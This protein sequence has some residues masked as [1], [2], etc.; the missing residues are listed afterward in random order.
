ML[1]FHCVLNR[2][3]RKHLRAGLAGKKL[4]LDD[5]ATT[6]ATLLTVGGTGDPMGPGSWAALPIL[7]LG[8]V[9]TKH[10]TGL[11]G[12]GPRAVPGHVAMA[13]NDSWEKENRWGL[14]PLT[15]HFHGLWKMGA[16]A[17]EAPGPEVVAVGWEVCPEAWQCP[18][19]AATRLSA[20]LALPRPGR[21]TARVLARERLGDASSAGALAACC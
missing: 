15:A 18:T 9:R 10:Q 21:G 4:H 5:S 6:R 16:R 1:L 3:V 13:P 14:C 2:E 11:S 17:G 7:G 20:M 19:P 8:A 12:L